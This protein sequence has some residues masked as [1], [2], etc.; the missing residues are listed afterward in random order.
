MEP[1]AR[2]RSAWRT[3]TVSHTTDGSRMENIPARPPAHPERWPRRDNPDRGARPAIARQPAYRHRSGRQRFARHRSR[4]PPRAPSP[5]DGLD[6]VGPAPYAVLR[7]PQ[8][9]ARFGM[10]LPLRPV[11][12]QG[13]RAGL[14]PP[15]WPGAGSRGTTHV[16]QTRLAPPPGQSGPSGT[17]VPVTRTTPSG[18]VRRN[19]CGTPG[20]STAV[21]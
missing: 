1:R 7:L 4:S 3:S 14:W 17:T 5:R 21:P 15:R 10:A 19:R 11:T 8:A 16:N 20:S 12:A 2:H 13:S 9:P 18:V 6:R